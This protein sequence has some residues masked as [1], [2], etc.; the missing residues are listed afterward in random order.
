MRTYMF[1][2]EIFLPWRV[3]SIMDFKV[4]IK[5]LKMSIFAFKK[6]MPLKAEI[7]KINWCL[8]HWRWGSRESH[9]LSNF[10][11]RRCKDTHGGT[12]NEKSHPNFKVSGNSHPNFKVTGLSASKEA[13]TLSSIKVLWAAWTLVS[14]WVGWQP[15]CIRVDLRLWWNIASF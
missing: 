10:R 11:A 7:N 2:T 15:I 9:C 14:A 4:Y 3:F 6:Y 8:H 13:I 5:I 12:L 1:L